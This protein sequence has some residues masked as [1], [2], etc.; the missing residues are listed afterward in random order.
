M[1]SA[2]VLTLIGAMVLGATAYVKF[3]P[4]AHRNVSEVSRPLESDAP[5]ASSTHKSRPSVGESDGQSG[6]QLTLHSPV[7]Q[8]DDVVLASTTDQ[9]PD[10]EQ[11]AVYL[12][13]EC[14]KAVHQD[15]VKA[16]SVQIKDH[17]ALLDFSPEIQ[18]GFGSSQEASFIKALQVSLG[19]LPDV[20][21]FQIL[22]NGQPIESLGH[23]EVTD[24]VDVIRPSASSK[25]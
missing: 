19:Q 10:G 4:M 18:D 3:G 2:L 25:A 15:T 22:V 1:R 16:N 12:A 13:N 11:P 23:F 5:V 8:G 6:T 14:L 20:N 24:P 7:I 21:K 17:I 9:L